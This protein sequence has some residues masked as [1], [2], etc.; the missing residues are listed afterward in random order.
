MGTRA[1]DLTD[2]LIT[3]VQ[4]PPRYLLMLKEL[5]KRTQESHPDYN[6]LTT[7][8]QKMERTNQVINE[9]KKRFEMMKKVQEAVVG[10]PI[11]SFDFC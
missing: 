10:N 3:P 7:A 6:N 5:L 4:R 2:L 11:V 9:R 1:P 8:V